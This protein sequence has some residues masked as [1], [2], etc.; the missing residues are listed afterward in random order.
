[1]AGPIEGWKEAKATP[2]GTYGVVAKKD[3][4]FAKRAADLKAMNE[5]LAK[6]KRG[7]MVE[8]D[9]LDPKPDTGGL[10]AGAPAAPQYVTTTS[11]SGGTS[12]TTREGV[13]LPNTPKMFQRNSEQQAQGALLQARLQA[14]QANARAKMIE[15][16]PE[17]RA[18]VRASF[19]AREAAQAKKVADAQ[20]KIATMADRASKM[21]VDPDRRW[22][23]ASPGTQIGMTFAA[24]LSGFIRGFNGQ[25]ANPILA[26]MDKMAKADIQA[27]LVDI[28]QAGKSIKSQRGILADLMKQG[29][30]IE[31]AKLQALADLKMDQADYLD[32]IAAKSSAPLAVAKAQQSAALIRAQGMR[33]GNAAAQVMADQK[34]TTKS[35]NWSS[36]KTPAGGAGAAGGKSK[37]TT[38][39]KAKLTAAL[40]ADSREDRFIGELLKY[41]GQKKGKVGLLAR[42]KG[43][44][45]KRL[46]F[47]DA[48]RIEGKRAKSLA[49]QVKAL[50]GVTAREDEIKRMEG[51]FPRFGDRRE[52]IL[53]KQL[54]AAQDRASSLANVVRANPNDSMVPQFKAGLRQHLIKIQRLRRALGGNK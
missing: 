40:D 19:A 41:Q 51:L 24:A 28:Q 21:S 16:R 26:E 46:P 45:A 31:V 52:V 36:K 15:Q 39:D 30:S 13:D 43:S 35:S 53:K 54:E 22:K 42:L 50:S 49:L 34:S 29:A 5:R 48:E 25:S 12:T 32:G 1:M 33:L 11:G 4:T 2:G 3:A 8:D 17:E 18:K 44:A 6:R 37:L 23:Q 9:S 38:A 7:F 10:I 47:T 27:Q 20:A 14:Q